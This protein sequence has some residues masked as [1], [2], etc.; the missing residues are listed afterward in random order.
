MENILIVQA[1]ILHKGDDVE[2]ISIIFKNRK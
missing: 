1:T 2:S